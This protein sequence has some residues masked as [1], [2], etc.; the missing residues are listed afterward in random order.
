MAEAPATGAGRTPSPGSPLCPRPAR[1]GA[2]ELGGERVVV[3]VATTAGAIDGADSAGDSGS[4]LA[5][6]L[7]AAAAGADLVELRLDLLSSPQAAGPQ[8]QAAFWHEAVL[9]VSAALAPTGTP[10]LATARSRREG[11]GA[12]MDPR[13]QAEAL[14]ALIDLQA[15]HRAGHA[16]ADALDVELST[17]ALPAL[18]ARAHE[19]GIAVVASS[20]DFTATP[21]D[22]EMLERLERMETGGAD[23]AKIAVMPRSEE[24]VDRALQVT[25][26][27]RACLSIPVA[28]IS[29]GE[30]GRRSRLEGWRYGSALTFAALS[31]DPA[32]ASAPGQPT[33]AAL[34]SHRDRS[35]TGTIPGGF[36]QAD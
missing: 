31:A 1:I 23:C 15:E 5:Q 20:H 16:V 24:D 8:A 7:A 33:I 22:G 25:A 6:A 28:V 32:A 14:G 2:A 19:A 13:E 18:A 3:A 34:L 29:M 35:K 9:A 30:R 12:A 21:P 17:G 10:L 11:G 4:A 27:A 36:P 26:R